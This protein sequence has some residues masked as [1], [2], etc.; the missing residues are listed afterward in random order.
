MPVIIAKVI[1]R[2]IITSREKIKPEF[3]SPFLR[4]VDGFL[5]CVLGSL[6]LIGSI[7]F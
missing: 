3:L 4:G 7:P 1:N 2:I 6:V 5:P